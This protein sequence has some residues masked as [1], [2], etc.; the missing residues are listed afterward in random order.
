MR[1][2]GP[3]NGYA[4]ISANEGGQCKGDIWGPGGFRLEHASYFVDGLSVLPPDMTIGNKT[5]ETL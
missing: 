3:R 4:A 5:V 1:V 2:S